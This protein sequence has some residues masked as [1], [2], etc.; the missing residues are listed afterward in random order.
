MTCRNRAIAA[1]ACVL[2]SPWF[3]AGQAYPPGTSPDLNRRVSIDVNQV[4]PSKVLDQLCDTIACTLDVDRKLPQ[5]DISLRLLNVR[6]RTAL[7]AVCAM[8]GCRWTLKGS[9]LVI[10]A[11]TPP[12]APG[13][14]QQWLE[15]MKTPLAGDK[16]NLDRVPLRDVLAMLSQEVGADVIIEGPDAATPVTEDLRGRSAMEAVYRIQSAVG[17]II[18]QGSMRL[19]PATGRQELRLEG[20]KDPGR[21]PGAAPARA[22]KPVEPGLTLPKVIS[23]VRPAYTSTALRA[24]IEGTVI[25]SVVVEKD[26]TVGDIRI[27]RSLDAS[28]ARRLQISPPAGPIGLDEEAIRAARLWRFVPGKKDG[29]PVPVEVTLE[30]TFTLRDKK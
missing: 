1:A 29:K 17:Y 22:F 6:A 16:W 25:L 4:A 15:K 20:R 7:D 8:V 28:A 12:P 11:T 18:G 2:L 30:L 21:E 5:P 3:A 9:T 10:T 19:N 27:L 14:G 13:Q 23:S 24:K 26:G